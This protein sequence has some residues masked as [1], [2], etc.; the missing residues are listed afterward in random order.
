M[1]ENFLTKDKVRA[2][3]RVTNIHKAQRKRRLSHEIYAMDWYKNLHQYSKNKIHC[4]CNLCKFRPIYDP[5]NKPAQ[6]LRWL[7][8]MTQQLADVE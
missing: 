2:T 6:V 4:S 8:D 5:D 3:R 7:I 1:D